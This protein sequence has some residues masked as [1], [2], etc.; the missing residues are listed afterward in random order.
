MVNNLVILA[1]GDGTRLKEVTG[2]VSKPLVKIGE[3]S[4]ITKIVKKLTVELKASSI[5]FLIQRKHYSQ[6]V[7]FLKTS[8]ELSNHDIELVV[9]E[10]KLG[11]G[12]AL[13]NFLRVSDKKEFYVSNADTLVKTDI[14]QFR[15]AKL[16][17]I[18]CTKVKNNS[19][20]GSVVV[21]ADDRIIR[22]ENSKSAK[23]VLVNTGIY[24]FERS[25]LESFDENVFDIEKSIFPIRAEQRKL[26]CF[27]MQIDFEDIGIPE[28]YYREVKNHEY[29]SEND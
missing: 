11:T 7:N 27:Q 20:F 4:I 18:L 10:Q 17:S 22:F 28:A 9:E 24:K 6:Y 12:G 16:N 14:S 5:Y 26:N 21:D 29:G 19:R 25:I 15:N 1:G 13:K 8:V 3:Q 2:D 23:N